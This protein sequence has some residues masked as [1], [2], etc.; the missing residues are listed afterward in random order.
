MRRQWVTPWIRKRDSKRAYYSII[1]R[2]GLTGKKILGRK[3]GKKTLATIP[4][5]LFCLNKN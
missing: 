2:L 1:N 3:H 5:I 4:I